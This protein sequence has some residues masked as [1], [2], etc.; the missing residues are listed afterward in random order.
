ML[1]SGVTAA[2][3]AGRWA[4]GL[5][6]RVSL[7]LTLL[8]PLRSQ[9]SLPLHPR[10]PAGKEHP[11]GTHCPPWSLSWVVPLGPAL[12]TGQSGRTPALIASVFY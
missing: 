12:L 5:S 9:L 2:R 10:G 8:E 11:G 4:A 1:Q 6:L 7:T 3:P